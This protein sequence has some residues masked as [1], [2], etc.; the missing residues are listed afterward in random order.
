MPR[1]LRIAS[2]VFLLGLG[3]VASAAAAD[4]PTVQLSIRNH[5]FEPA[6]VTIPAGRKVVLLVH[7]RD[8]TPEEFESNEFN[9]EKVIMGGR[10]A[11]IY[12][13]PLEAGRYRFFGEFHADTAQGVLVVE[14]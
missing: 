5:R 11:R 9:R 4:L 2:L 1:L 14:D 13:G 6:T 3:P 10:C 8:A 7:N 12:V